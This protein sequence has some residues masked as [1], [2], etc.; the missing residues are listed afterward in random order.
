MKEVLDRWGFL[1]RRC[2]NSMQLNDISKLLEKITKIKIMVVGDIGLDSYIVGDV[3][4]ISPEAPVPVVDVNDNYSRLG[5]SANVV[6]NIRALG[7]ECSLIGVVGNDEN[8]ELINKELVKIGVDPSGIVV[9][10]DRPTTH[11][12]RVLASRLH[13]VVRI[14]KEDRSPLAD[15]SR[16]QIL[17]NIKKGLKHCDAVIMEDYGKGLFKAD[18]GVD[19]INECIKA[20]KPVFVDPSRSTKANT[21][22]GATLLKPNMDEARILSGVETD[23]EHM[24]YECGNKLMKDLSL[25]HLVITRGKE[26]M[27][28]FAKGSEPK[29]IPTFALEVFDVSGAGDT[30]IAC[31][32]LARSAGFNIYESAFFANSAAA[33]VVGK[34]GTSV[35]T[36]AEVMEFLREHHIK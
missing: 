28:V 20:G 19:I 13:H 24:L 31:L 2:N 22:K 30:V 35:V 4:K 15:K 9:C 16:E 8:S 27:T 14:D 34:V 36:P 21:Y 33:I 1:L 10:M 12:T 23:N 25:E 11:K 17:S 18:L 3:K 32:A 7:A 26:G 29:T 6:S 5:L